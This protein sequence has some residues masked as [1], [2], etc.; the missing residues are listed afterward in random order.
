MMLVIHRYLTRLMAKRLL[1]IFGILVTFVLFVDLMIN[2]KE[3]IQSRDGDMIAIAKYAILRLPEIASL[4]LAPATLL[5]ALAVLASLI[6]HFELVAIWNSHIS[7]LRTCLAV[8][9]FAFILGLCQFIIDGE[10]VP[11]TLQRLTDWGVGD[12]GRTLSNETTDGAFW[13]HSGTDIVRL[14]SVVFDLAKIES[15]CFNAI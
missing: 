2:A 11:R 1:V 9:P 15:L 14:P 8:A 12:Y 13:L 10:A 4:L 5:A 3:V 7:P 6:R